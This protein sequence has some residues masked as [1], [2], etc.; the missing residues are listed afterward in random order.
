VRGS[1]ADRLPTWYTLL[2]HHFTA[3]ALAALVAL[4]AIR[5][6]SADPVQPWWSL[7]GA[8]VSFAIITAV[9]LAC[10]SQ[11]YAYASTSLAGLAVFLYW[12]A[13]ATRPWHTFAFGN[14]PALPEALALALTAA[15]GLWLA[16]EIIAQRR[17]NQSFDT[18]YT[19]PRVHIMAVGSILPLYFLLRLTFAV[20][21]N[22]EGWLDLRSGFAGYAPLAGVATLA[23]GAI[24]AALLWDR[25]AFIAI[26][27]LYTWGGIAWLL[28]IGLCWPWLPQIEHRIVAIFAALALH[29]ALSGQLW[30]YGANLSAIGT[31]LGISDPI[32]GLTRTSLWLP[33]VSVLLASLAVVADLV[34]V[35]TVRVDSLRTIA[36]LG[37]AVC[38][39]GILCLAQ[40]RRQ[41]TFQLA[42]LLM[43]GLSAVYLAWAQIT[44]DHTTALWMTRVFRLVMVLAALTF[45]YGLALPQW[46]LT[47]GSWHDA[48]RKAGYIAGSAAIVAFVATLALE[49]A[50]FRPGVNTIAVN[51]A[52][53]IAVAVVLLFLI[54]GLISLALLPGRDPLLL[55]ETNRQAYVYGAQVIAAL[56][57]AHLYVCRPLWFDSVLRPYWPFIVMGLAFIGVGSGELFRRWNI[58]VLAEPL[59]RSGALLPILP[60]IG[61]WALGR[62]DEAQILLVVGLLY[63]ALSFTRK[64][65]PAMVAAAL[66][67][68]GAL[69]ALLLDY[70]FNFAGHPQFW[71]IPPALSA[72]LA[73]HINRHR[74]R[75]DVLTAIRYAATVVIYVSST[76]EIFLRGIGDS[77]W[78]PM[79]LLVLA[80]A[81]TLAGIALRV[82]AFLFL[83]TA[84]TLLALIAMIAHAARA[85]EHVWPWWVFGISVG[86]A[87]LI[88]FGIF[89]KKRPE[90]L[91]LISRLKAWEL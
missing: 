73:S 61:M 68:N 21:Y 55:S 75:P 35:L 71:L 59:E 56:L 48:T 40:E 22:H 43:A 47:S 46:L 26:P 28:V 65:W 44:P 57:F 85:I 10:R 9:G 89:E 69:W 51:D 82:R 45:L 64:S 58:R 52:Q 33:V 6:N 7:A 29:V 81:G 36:A 77:L 83:G 8:L 4:L 2:P 41:S 86:I 17:R 49:V 11:F 84:F 3:A 25:R 14:M 30:S 37:P 24:A 63:L 76:S 50:L 72:L 5:G 34:F 31:K 78:P 91:A 53:V 23:L 19:G 67:G 1:A 13:P 15:A 90:V 79:V 12:I 42:A 32:G 80:V 18:W 88:L 74:L 60:V 62:S 66:A 38:A 39:W 87:I 54:A 20:F 16:C 27:S 70:E